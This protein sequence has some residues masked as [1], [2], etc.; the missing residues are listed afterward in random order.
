MF[1]ASN[2][3][4][5]YIDEKVPIPYSLKKK[6][7]MLLVNKEKNQSLGITNCLQIFWMLECCPTWL[8]GHLIRLFSL[9]SPGLGCSWL[10]SP[11]DR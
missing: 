2:I 1:L 8:S 6:D 7:L 10:S 3:S 4:L 11:W 5:F 9:R